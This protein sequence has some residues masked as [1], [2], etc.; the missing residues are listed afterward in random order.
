MSNT[1][2]HPSTMDG[3]KRLAKSI[4]RERSLSHLKSLDE[5]ARQAGFHNFR[6]AQNTLPVGGARR[7]AKTHPLFITAYWRNRGGRGKGRE[8]LEIQLSLPW[9]SLVTKSQLKRERTLMRFRGDAP[10]HLELIDDV[11][12]Q[13]RAR[14]MVCAAARAMQFIDATKL[15]PSSKP[16]RKFHHAG[17]RLPAVD[18]ATDWV[19]P[20]TSRMLVIDEPYDLSVERELT[21]RA[22]WA[23]RH[24]FRIEPA[25][26]AGLYVPGHSVMYLISHQDDGIPLDPILKALSALPPPVVAEDWQ[27]ESSAYSPVFVTPGRQAMPARKRERRDPFAALRPYGNSVGYVQTFVGPQRR[28][29]ARMPI[30][31]HEEI[32]KHL[33]SVLSV[34]YDRR[35]VAKQVMTIRSELDEWVQREYGHDELPNERFS[36]MYYGDSEILAKKSITDAERHDLLAKLDGVAARLSTHYPDCAPLRALLRSIGSAKK[37]VS[38]WQ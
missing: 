12:S 2:I 8:T 37:A 35:G 6:H 32:G 14:D 33:K 3:I 36:R 22:R 26:W 38:R 20:T 10:D 5:A 1:T 11:D 28:P 29:D 13:E 24:G 9:E 23:D 17:S 19:D 21:E 25:G 31:V 18:H 34:C 27:G 7:T 16:Y 4:K 15:R 30:E